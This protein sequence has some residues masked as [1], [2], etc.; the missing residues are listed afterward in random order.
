MGR[1]ELD[2]VEIDSRLS[3]IRQNQ[4]TAVILPA[5]TLVAIIAFNHTRCLVELSAYR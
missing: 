4:P 5:S 2:C 3:T 1:I